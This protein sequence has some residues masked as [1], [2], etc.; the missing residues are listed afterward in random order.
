MIVIIEE[1]GLI[2][3]PVQA[4]P[5]CLLLFIWDS[6]NVLGMFLIGYENVL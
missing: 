3:N 6:Q 1:K 4:S 2:Q 5:S